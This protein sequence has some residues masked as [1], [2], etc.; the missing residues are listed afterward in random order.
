MAVDLIFLNLIEINSQ[1][2]QDK[3]VQHSWNK[4]K[5]GSTHVALNFITTLKTARWECDSN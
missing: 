3:K 1:P 5:I 2:E 4:K